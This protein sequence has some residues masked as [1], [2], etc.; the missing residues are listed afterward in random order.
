[1]APNSPDF[2]AGESNGQRRLVGY[3]P[4]GCKEADTTGQLSM[5]AESFLHS[6][7][8]VRAHQ[9]SSEQGSML[10]PDTASVSLILDFQPL[11]L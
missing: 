8:H 7:C 4:R 1:M 5:R 11:K 9:V 10:S 6:F 3:S 2:L